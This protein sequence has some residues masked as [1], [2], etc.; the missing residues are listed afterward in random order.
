GPRL[1]ARPGRRLCRVSGRG[2][3]GAGGATEANTP[4]ARPTRG[5]EPSEAGSREGSGG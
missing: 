4:G 1:D 5:I 2:R 3:G